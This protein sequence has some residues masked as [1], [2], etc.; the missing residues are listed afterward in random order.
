MLLAQYY[1]ELSQLSKKYFQRF[2]QCNNI[3]L[4]IAVRAKIALRQYKIKHINVTYD[5]I[6]V[7]NY[8]LTYL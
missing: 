6:V 1:S 3:I 2:S 8:A 7:L 4:E 5:I